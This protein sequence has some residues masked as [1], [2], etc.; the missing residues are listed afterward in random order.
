MNVDVSPDGRTIAFDLLGDIYTM[1]IAGG[2]PTRITS[3]LAFDMQPRFSPDGRLIAFTSDRGGGDNIWVM[4]ADG[5]GRA[6]DHHARPSPAQRAD[7][8]PGRPLSSPRASISPPSARSAPARSG[9]TMLSGI[10]ERRAAGRAA[11][12]AVPEGARRA[13]LS[14]PTAAPSISAATPRRAT[15]SNMPRI[16]TSRCS[17]SSATTS[18]PA[19]ASRSPAAPAARS[20]RRPRPTAAGSPTSTAPAAAAG[21]SSRTCARARS[22]QV[23]ADLDQ[24][25]QETWAVHGVYPNMDWTPDSQHASS[26][27]PAARSAASI[28]DGSG[29]AEIPFEVNDTR[30]VI[31]PPRPQVEVAPGQLHH[32]HAALRRGLAGRQPGRVRDAR[33]ALHPRHRRAARRGR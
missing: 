10:G 23:Y 5:I 29:A 30:V 2:R 21:C 9:S 24:D 12:S 7:L 14:R 26:S 3:G 19:S 11:Q 32:P 18:P 27:G 20:G 16:R 6:G 25:L 4:N 33:P 31:D 28:A 13:G 1:P 22:A 17:R 8:E 15:S